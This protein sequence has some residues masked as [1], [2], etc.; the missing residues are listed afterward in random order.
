VR[1][2]RARRTARRR[3]TEE[4][5]AEPTSRDTWPALLDDLLERIDAALAR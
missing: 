2:V 1:Q 5:T 3:P 4:E